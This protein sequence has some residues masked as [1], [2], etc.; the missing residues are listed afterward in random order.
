MVE[1]ES[2]SH[3]SKPRSTIE[4]DTISAQYSQAIAARMKMVS[5][6]LGDSSSDEEEEEEEEEGRKNGA[7]PAVQVSSV[8][9]SSSDK[10]SIKEKKKD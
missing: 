7:G 8:I 9:P 1:S 6:W 4:V 5:S 3:A 10:D 2:Y